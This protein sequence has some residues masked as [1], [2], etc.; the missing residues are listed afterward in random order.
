MI[1]IRYFRG[2]VETRADLSRFRQKP[3][4]RLLAGLILVFIGM[5]LGWPAISVCGG[6]ALW[7]GKT[8][9]ITLVAPAV[10]AISWVIYGL[11]FV[12]GG[13]EAVRYL[14][15][16]NRWLARVIVEWLLGPADT[17]ALVEAIPTDNAPTAPAEPPQK[18]P[19]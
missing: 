12:V 8:V 15:D 3:E 5:I 14:R 16:F 11:G 13:V 19:D 10:Y 6:L 2:A 9:F 7:T 4:K 1:R 17:A 18:A